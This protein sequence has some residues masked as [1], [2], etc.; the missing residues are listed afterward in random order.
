MDCDW[1]RDVLLSLMVGLAMFRQT[2]ALWVHT[3][4][5]HPTRTHLNQ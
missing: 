1:D 2:K 5:T 4:A 3:D